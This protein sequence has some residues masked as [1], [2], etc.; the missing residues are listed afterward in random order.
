MQNVAIPQ[1]RYK[2]A[3]IVYSFDMPG[4][5]LRVFDSSNQLDFS[6][7]RLRFYG[8]TL[9]QGYY[10]EYHGADRGSRRRK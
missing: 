10:S 6:S 9:S 4:N 2:S 1:L 3:V 5:W 8:T 7:L